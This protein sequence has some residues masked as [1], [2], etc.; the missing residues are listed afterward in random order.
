MLE[1][2]HYPKVSTALDATRVR[3]AIFRRDVVLLPLIFLAT[4]AILLVSGE[5]IARLLYPQDD[6]PEA[7]EFQTMSGSNFHPGCTS[8]SK[9]WEGEWITQHFN[10][11]GYRT[12]EP[13][14]PRPAG[15]LRV[16]VVGSST[17]RGIFVNYEDSFAARASATLSERCGGLV[18]F[19]NL[20]TEPTDVGRIDQRMP[21]VL[22][23]KPTAIVMV[24]GPFDIAHVMDLAPL[25]QAPV[26]LNRG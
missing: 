17:A 26:M 8:H 20:G 23:L 21:E 13:C 18:D 15:A 22:A 3:G 24:I 7:C 10:D 2:T 4:M 5:I 12:E 14:V 1:A 11:C 6:A 9:M 25:V 19:Q 16:A